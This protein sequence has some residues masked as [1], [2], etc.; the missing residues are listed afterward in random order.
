MSERR[1]RMVRDRGSYVVRRP[2]AEPYR[3]GRAE[4]WQLLRDVALGT[5]ALAG[6]VA[7]ILWL[8]AAS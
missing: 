3:A 5:L 1:V 6:V 2:Q 4:T 8:L 7:A